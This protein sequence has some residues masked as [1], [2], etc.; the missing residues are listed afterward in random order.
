VDGVPENLNGPASAWHLWQG[1]QGSLFSADRVVS[2]LR[3]RFLSAAQAFY[4][5]NSSPPFAQCW[6]DGQQI[7][8]AGITSIPSGGIP[9][10]DPGPDFLSA[11]TTDVM[12]APGQTPAQADL[13]S[14][15]LDAPL[16]AIAGRFKR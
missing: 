15:Q 11:T 8:A 13:L 4:L 7:G 3:D 16:T 12:S 6:G 10:T 5:D 14:R 9:V 1:G 2:S